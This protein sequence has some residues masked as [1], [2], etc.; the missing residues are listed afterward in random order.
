MKE[1][2]REQHCYN[3]NINLKIIC[4]RL[5]SSY[6]KNALT[7]I[8]SMLETKVKIKSLRKEKQKFCKEMEDMEN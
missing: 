2:N 4:Q 8:M 5:W 6:H 7:A 3:S 1:D